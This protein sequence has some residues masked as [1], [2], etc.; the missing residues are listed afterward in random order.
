[1]LIAEIAESINIHRPEPEFEDWAQLGYFR[2]LDN[3]TRWRLRKV[4]AQAVAAIEGINDPALESLARCGLLRTAHWA[5]DGRKQLPSTASFRKTFLA[6]ASLI[7]DGAIAL[8]KASCGF[9]SDCPK[10]LNRSIIGLDGDD[11]I[12]RAGTPKLIITSP[13]YPGVH[14][15]YHRW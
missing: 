7:A 3:P 8:H 6:S 13:P 4:I 1:K 9:P 12:Q 2:N 5:L 14:V 11:E 15:L 10:V